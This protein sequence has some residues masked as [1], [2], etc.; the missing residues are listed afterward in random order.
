MIQVPQV[1]AGSLLGCPAGF[2][3]LP[4]LCWCL[5]S[6][7]GVSVGRSLCRRLGAPRPSSPPQ[8]EQ[9]ASCSRALS[10]LYPCSN[11]SALNLGFQSQCDCR[12]RFDFASCVSDATKDI[13]PPV[14]CKAS[15]D[16]VLGPPPPGVPGE[17]PHGRFPPKLGGFGPVPARIRAS[18][19]I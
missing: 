11:A 1:G 17:C 10:S 4:A 6:C 15:F 16:F 19:Y 8:G 12:F 2:P 3:T 7:G 5:C 18:E 9:P 14:V 13:Q